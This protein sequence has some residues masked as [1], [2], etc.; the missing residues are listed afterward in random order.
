MEEKISRFGQLKDLFEGLGE[1]V[2]KLERMWE[3]VRN[4]VKE[5]EEETKVDEQMMQKVK[6][7]IEKAIKS[8]KMTSMKE[9]DL[10]IYEELL[11]NFVFCVFDLTFI[12]ENILI[13][14]DFECKEWES[15]SGKVQ[16]YLEWIPEKLKKFSQ[17]YSLHPKHDE[18]K[19]WIACSLGKEVSKLWSYR[20]GCFLFYRRG[21][22]LKSNRLNE[23]NKEEEV[24]LIHTC[25]ESL[26]DSLQS[27]GEMD[28]TSSSQLLCCVYIG[29]LCVW[30]KTVFSQIPFDECKEEFYYENGMKGLK[31]F[32]DTVNKEYN[33]SLMGYSNE[34]PLELIS[35]LEEIYG[36]K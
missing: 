1:K 7:S 25:I 9:F 13:D 32:I 24:K 18:D 30:R 8:K 26:L 36:K 15:K 3:E 17:I 35:K 23:L 33:F 27:D 21:T 2:S 16:E 34:R 22:L 4:W 28:V 14:Q 11:K 12:M 29:E 19:E 20:R 31:H 5:S 10:R 6:L